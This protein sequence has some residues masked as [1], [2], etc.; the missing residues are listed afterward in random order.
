M[1]KCKSFF[2]LL[3]L[4]WDNS[5]IVIDVLE[6]VQS[7]LPL[8]VQALKN[9]GN[10]L[11]E[12][13]NFIGSVEGE[14]GNTL[15]KVGGKFNS[16]T[17][18]KL[19]LKT[20]GFMDVF[21]RSIRSVIDIPIHDPPDNVKNSLNNIRVLTMVKLEGQTTPFQET[22]TYLDLEGQTISG[23]SESSRDALHTASQGLLDCAGILEELI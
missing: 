6:K 8:V 13:A 14:I 23:I 11:E 4:L 1:G 12:A 9:S 16:I 20:D 7:K 10:K 22:I 3:K 18:P 15:E 17:V 19:E 21:M 2:K 5:E